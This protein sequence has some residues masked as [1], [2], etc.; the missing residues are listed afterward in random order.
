MLPVAFRPMDDPTDPIATTSA[1]ALPEPLKRAAQAMLLAIDATSAERSGVWTDLAFNRHAIELFRAQYELVAPYR[2]WCDHELGERGIDAQA[3]TRWQQVPALPIAAFKSHR[4]AGHT[5]ALDVAEWHS[6]GTSGHR[7]SRHTLPDLALYEASLLASARLALVPRPDDELI[8]VQLAPSRAALPGSSLS[9]MLDLVRTCLC[10][11]GGTWAGAD[12]GVDVDGAW[13][14]LQHAQAEGEP[15]LLLATSFALVHLL[16][17]A[18][19]TPAL[20]LP[21]GSRL[22]D[23]GGYKGRTRE[24]ARG[25]LVYRVSERLGIEPALCENEY[26]MS[27]L[28]SQA[29]LGTIAARLGRPLPGERAHPRAHWQPPWMRT[30]VVD[31]VT[32]NEVADG[33]HGLLVHHDLANA[34]SCAA[35]RSEDVGVRRGTSYALVGRAPGAEL[36][37]CSLRLEDV[38]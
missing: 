36:R 1:Q 32:L 33:E 26:G 30:R 15:V 4:V 25:E 11:D 21:P 28:S 18:E 19:A 35:I 10:H 27:E 2:T 6:S 37:G 31:P 24:F 9:H 34:Y 20:R 8:A 14:R 38:L 22:M 17:Q 23:T 16:E 3:V 12:G 29:Y 7:P 13:R 5:P